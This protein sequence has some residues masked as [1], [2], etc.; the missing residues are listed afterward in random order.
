MCGKS[1]VRDSQHRLDELPFLSMV[2]PRAC[3]GRGKPDHLVDLLTPR[4]GAYEYSAGGVDDPWAA[5]G[6]AV[7]HTPNVALGKPEKQP[8]GPILF[9]EIL[10]QREP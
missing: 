2:H 10:N 9:K 4:A 8:I 5:G 7:I 6:I 3:F 1:A